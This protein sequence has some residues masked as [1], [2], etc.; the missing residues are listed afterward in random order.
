VAV[1]IINGDGHLNA[2]STESL[3][4]QRYCV[5]SLAFNYFP[6][7]HSPNELTATIIGVMRGYS[8]FTF[9]LRGTTGT[10][11]GNDRGQTRTRKLHNFNESLRIA[12]IARTEITIFSGSDENNLIDLALKRTY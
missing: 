2:L 5:G 7:A 6:A 9:S 11:Q 10:V 4:I 1:A 12:I 8:E 3:C